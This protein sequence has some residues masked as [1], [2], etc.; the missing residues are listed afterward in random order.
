MSEVGVIIPGQP[1]AQGRPRMTTINGHPR[2]Y[3]PEKSRSWKGAAQVHML[4]VMR[5]L[6]LSPL[7]G[8]VEV[9]VLAVFACPT[10]DYR[11]R[12]PRERR[13]KPGKP[14]A[15]NIAK[16]CLDAGNGVLYHDD[17]QVARLHVVKVIG[18]QREPAHVE[19]LVTTL[20][21]YAGGF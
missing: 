19:V 1:V 2:A 6:G 10:T 7:E 4:A 20:R 13:W 5:A 17:A 14:D 16:A 15:E 12:E 18:A 8:P 11:K 21:D 9:S 3:D